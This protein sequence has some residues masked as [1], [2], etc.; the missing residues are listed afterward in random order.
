[1][2]RDELQT[3]CELG[4]HELMRM[5]YIEAERILAAAERVARD[6]RDFD[7]L[8]RL[9]MPL[10]ETRRQ[11]RI[12]CG[13]GDVALDLFPPDPS[14]PMNADLIL[15]SFSFGQ[16]LVAGWGSIDV[17]NDVRR[18]A[19]DRGLFLE[20]FLGAVYPTDEGLLIA[21]VP[22]DDTLLP[23]ATE[24]SREDLW[25]HL[26]PNSLLLRPDELP[27]G[28]R[29]GTTATFAEVASFW[30][31]LHLP[32]LREAD[33]EPDPLRRIELYRRTITVDYACELAHQK[34]SHTARE[35]ARASR[36]TPS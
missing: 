34:L 19:H 30:E 11:I 8:S 32:F 7:T 1:M 10:Q 2:T 23:D 21:I 29:R 4:Q 9:Y 27:R 35:L 25:K 12:R 3:Q 36:G 31:R 6:Q 20:T 15:E 22:T 28:F 18:L 33:A 5:N 26:P 16:L 13:E 14:A 17:A 24:R